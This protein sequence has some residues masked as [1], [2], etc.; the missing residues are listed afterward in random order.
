[1]KLRNTIIYLIGIPAVGKYTTAKEIGRLTGA[2]VV[3]NQLINLP[4][5][6]VVGYDGTDAFP[7]PKAAGAHIEKIHRAVLAVI[8]DYCQ[9]EDSF[10]FTNVL[11]AN[12]PSD[13]AWFR[14]IE[15][16]AKK[17]KAEFFPVWLTCEAEKIYQ[18]KNT[19]ERR[20]RLKEI[21]LS[22]IKRWSEEF[23]VLKVPHPNAL[24]LDTTHSLPE[25]TARRILN[26][27]QKITCAKD[28]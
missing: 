6:T 10:V 25:Q 2:K 22:S 13:L 20:A 17:R 21:D 8:R 14:R 23:E 16:V 19:P 18:R 9:P 5:F 12:T 3:D 1:M 7:F 15:R 24:T 27:V 11:D 26:H 4:V 28:F